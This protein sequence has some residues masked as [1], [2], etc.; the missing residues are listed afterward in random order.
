MP[1]SPFMESPLSSVEAHADSSWNPFDQSFASVQNSIDNGTFVSSGYQGSYDS[2]VQDNTQN[3]VSLAAIGEANAFDYAV[4]EENPR[5]TYET[6][7][8]T[9]PTIDYQSQEPYWGSRRESISSNL[10][11]AAPYPKRRK[12]SDK[13]SYRSSHQSSHSRSRSDSKLES[14]PRLRSTTQPSRSTTFSSSSR[15]TKSLSSNDN[16]RGRTNHNQVEKQY[17]NRLNGQFE[18][19]LNVLPSEDDR[20]GV[21]S[22]VS[23]AEVLILAK[24]HIVELEREKVMLESRRRELES[25]V[26]DLKRRF[27]AMGGVCMP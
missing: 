17:R 9:S 4:D 12:S 10:P 20:D 14:V 24:R 2:S 15:P 5:E 1:A 22:R 6:S 26:D 8:V 11:T 18:T 19:L 3:F 27:V 7:P 21:K 25:D 23:K 16:S 13:G